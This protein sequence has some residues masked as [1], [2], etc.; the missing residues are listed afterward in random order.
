MDV[1]TC[2]SGA[3]C[4]PIQGQGVCLYSDGTFATA[5]DFD[6]I[7]RVKLPDYV[8]YAFEGFKAK[9]G[10]TY[11]GSEHNY[12]LGVF[13][14]NL[15]FIEEFE[16]S[17]PHSYWLGIN[18]YTDMTHEE[19]VAE[20]VGGVFAVE[21]QKNVVEL[22]ESNLGAGVDWRTKGAVT[23]VKNQE[24]CGSCWAFSAVAAM[25][26]L[27]FQTNGKLQS[28][29]E[30]QLVDCS[31]SQG[32]QGCHGGLMDYAFKYA[33]SHKMDLESDYKYKA[34]DG[35][36]EEKSYTGVFSPKSYSDVRKN[37]ESQLQ[38]ASDKQVVS[39]AIEADKTAFQ[40]YKGGVFS[41][42]R[43]GKKLDHGVTL[44]GY[45]D[46]AW[47]VKNSWG[48]SWGESG[49]IRMAKPGENICGILEQPSYPT[50]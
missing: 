19:F 12:R 16:R 10:K 45:T 38:A 4:Q 6:L 5:A 3:K 23:P 27:N 7:P 44:V 36:C 47:I 30:Q 37:S 14:D 20:K 13:Y 15:K 50:M 11:L 24:H 49:Y 46:E 34:K 35:R 18:E 43:C 31:K 2:P 17:G 21:E 25:E 40:H 32:N 33:E 9:Y 29:S 42:R 41:D 8:T 48:A 22:D 39:V 28:F 1:G 26:G